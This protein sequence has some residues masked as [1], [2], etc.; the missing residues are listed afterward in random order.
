MGRRKVKIAVDTNVLV[1]AAV[2][3]NPHQARR[4][5]K[6]LRDAALVAVSLPV[7]CEFLWVMSRG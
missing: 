3:D 4:A 5:E 2:Q 1:R 6:G 7:L